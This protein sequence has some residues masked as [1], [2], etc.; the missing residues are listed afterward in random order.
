M[1]RT[2]EFVLCVL[3]GSCIELQAMVRSLPLTF[4][5]RRQSEITHSITQS[6]NHSITQ[7]CY[8]RGYR[9]STIDHRFGGKRPSNVACPSFLSLIMD[10]AKC[11]FQTGHNLQGI[12]LFLSPSLSFVLAILLLPDISYS[13]AQ[14]KSIKLC[15]ATVL[16]NMHI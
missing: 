14:N 10:S 7:S 8:E 9:A 6:L 1:S 11:S 16:Y 4:A 2:E 3:G 15:T 5:S 13:K 12:S